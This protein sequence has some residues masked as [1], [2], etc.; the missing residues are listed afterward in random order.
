MK[1][2]P[3]TNPRKRAEAESELRQSAAWSDEDLNRLRSLDLRVCQWVKPAET[4]KLYGITQRLSARRMRL[5]GSAIGHR[6]QQCIEVVPDLSAEQCAFLYDVIR[7]VLDGERDAFKAFG[8]AIPSQNPGNPRTPFMAA[9]Y[10][11]AKRLV[12]KARHKRVRFEIAE[13]YAVTAARISQAHTKHR[14]HIDVWI[15][16]ALQLADSERIPA[17]LM[18][19]HL[20]A[21]VRGQSEWFIGARKGSTLNDTPPENLFNVTFPLLLVNRPPIP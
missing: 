20:A 17:E 8:L 4:V 1:R 15:S 7:R 11:L 6:S 21:L 18:L 2:A 14:E 19:R 10:E 3:R 5:D 16:E 12:P 13:R 9:E